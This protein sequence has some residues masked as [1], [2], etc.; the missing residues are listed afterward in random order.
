MTKGCLDKGLSSFDKP[1]KPQKKEKQFADSTALKEAMN[2]FVDK[3]LPLVIKDT[4]WKKTYLSPEIRERYNKLKRFKVSPQQKEQAKKPT[5]ALQL[6]SF[7][8]VRVRKKM[9]QRQ[10]ENLKKRYE[11]VIS[12]APLFLMPS[13]DLRYKKMHAAL[14]PEPDEVLVHLRAEGSERI[15]K[16]NP[17]LLTPMDSN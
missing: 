7:D 12:C 8:E 11:G 3:I 14:S 16:I 5:E 10:F 1:E 13:S 15:G 6:A 4:D 2:D 9:T 17:I